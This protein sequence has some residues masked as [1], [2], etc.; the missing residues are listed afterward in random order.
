[1]Y[2]TEEAMAVEQPA[3]FITIESCHKELSR[4][5][6]KFAPIMSNGTE[7]APQESPSMNA[8]DARLQLLSIFG[9]FPA[10]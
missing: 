5:E 10:E 8:L 7:K 3:A 6:N 9:I 4:I 1:M 2:P